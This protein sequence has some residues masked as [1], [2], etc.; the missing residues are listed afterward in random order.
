MAYG[1]RL[2]VRYCAFV[3]NDASVAAAH[4]R[5][6]RAATIWP[7]G[8]DQRDL[9]Q[10][11]GGAI[12][13]EPEYGQRDPWQNFLQPSTLLTVTQ[14]SFVSNSAVGSGGAVYMRR[15]YA[16]FSLELTESTFTSNADQS[17]IALMV[18]ASPKYGYDRTCRGDANCRHSA[19]TPTG[20]AA[21]LWGDA[22][23][24]TRQ[25]VYIHEAL[26]WCFSS[27][28]CGPG[29]QCGPD[30]KCRCPT[31]TA[32]VRCN[33]ECCSTWCPAI[34]GCYGNGCRQDGAASGIISGGYITGCSSTSNCAHAAC[35]RDCDHTC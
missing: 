13:V 22:I 26:S 29:G 28:D 14:C 19:P 32:D 4:E 11:G 30:H 3:A 6:R 18:A 25:P 27:A 9:D 10:A 31:G 34:G 15:T 21:I 12:S 8:V 23:T 2:V 7:N 17:N 33:A 20:T 1:A 35:C 24:M 16:P 5:S